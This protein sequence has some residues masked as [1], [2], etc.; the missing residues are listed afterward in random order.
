MK[1]LLALITLVIFSSCSTTSKKTSVNVEDIKD[2]DF[3]QVK[4]V[5]YNKATDVLLNAKSEFSGVTNKE[6]LDRIF[7]YDGD[8]ELPGPMG[9]VA[10]LCYEKKFSEAYQ[11]IELGNRSFLNNPIYWNQVGTCF[12]QEGNLRKAL[13]FYNKSLSLRSNYAPAL[14]NLGV[15]YVKKGDFPRALVAFERARKTRTFSRVPRLNLANLYL[16][17]GL[18]DDA[19]SEISVLRSL[20]KSDVD[21]LN[22]SATAKLM[23]NDLKG[24]VKDF[25]RID[26]SFYELPSIGLNYA[27]A[28]HMSGAREKAIDIFEDVEIDKNKLWRSYRVEVA[29]I[30]GVKK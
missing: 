3:K 5:K 15:M 20:S 12:L 10:K 16:S 6:S 14:N 26:G 13:L 23:K 30:L 7:K 8:I 18:Y 4:Q 29:D 11:L 28:L 25:E 9:K 24:A 17:F 22:L 1:N 19:L 2:E 21:V 27:L